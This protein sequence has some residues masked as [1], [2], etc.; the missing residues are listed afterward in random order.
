MRGKNLSATKGPIKRDG[1]SSKE[2]ALRWREMKAEE[3]LLFVLSKDRF[4][5]PSP[6]P[7]FF[8]NGERGL[9]GKQVEIWTEER[10]KK[11]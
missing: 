2:R 4:R 11:S 7:I 6:S 1:F 10:K 3:K 9:T 5:N 8:F